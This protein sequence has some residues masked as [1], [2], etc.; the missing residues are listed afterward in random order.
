MC[1]RVTCATCNKPSWAGCGM[2]V[3]SVSIPQC[4]AG[5]AVGG[6]KV[7][8]HSQF[9]LAVK[10]LVIIHVSMRRHLLECRKRIAASA[11]PTHR[12]CRTRPQLESRYRYAGV[13]VVLTQLRC[14]VIVTTSLTAG[15]LQPALSIFWCMLI[16]LCLSQGT[17][18]FT[19]PMHDSLNKSLAHLVPLDF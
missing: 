9:S 18:I 2:H 16:S 8:R 5:G 1:R 7:F 12:L 15:Q 17:F 3:D 10:F 11:S 13:F 14:L 19:K 6:H 4:P